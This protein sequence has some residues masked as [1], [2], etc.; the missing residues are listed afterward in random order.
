MSPIPIGKVIVFVLENGKYI[1]WDKLQPWLDRAIGRW[2]AQEY[3]S[4]MF[5]S[6]DEPRSSLVYGWRRY[7]LKPKRD[8]ED[9][10]A[11]TQFVTSMLCEHYDK[12]EAKRQLNEQGSMKE[13][14]DVNENESIFSI[15][16]PGSSVYS[17][18]VG[19][20][21][22]TPTE[23]P[24]LPIYIIY[25]SEI[26]KKR[27]EGKIASHEVVMRRYDGK[28]LP[29]GI[30]KIH[31]KDEFKKAFKGIPIDKN[32]DL[33]AGR[34]SG[35]SK[36]ESDYLLVTMMPN[37][38]TEIASKNR[39]VHCIISGMYGPGTLALELLLQNKNGALRLMDE[40]REGKPWFQSLFKIHGI[41]HGVK[42]PYKNSKEFSIGSD[43]EHLI[44]IPLRP[45]HYK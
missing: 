12:R 35:S 26:Y 18:P 39:K 19:F 22:A 15:G 10:W 43:L 32:G 5:E 2:K 13:L 27:Q 33:E 4:K 11:A 6:F 9:H 38:K 44:T 45:E 20:D 7:D 23:T 16:G 8:P 3:R 37:L 40:E 21:I 28:D 14:D 30:W 36:L 41:E 25:D 29:S 17:K 24:S 42:L 34:A 31:I 1:P